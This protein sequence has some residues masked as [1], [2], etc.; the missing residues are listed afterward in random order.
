LDTY[1]PLYVCVGDS[2]HREEVSRAKKKKGVH[3]IRH[4]SL[5][6]LVASSLAKGQSASIV[7]PSLSL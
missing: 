7:H 1:E 4:T 3:I 2:V 5:V 6:F